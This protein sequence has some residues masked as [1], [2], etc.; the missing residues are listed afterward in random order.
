VVSYH[1]RTVNQPY[2]QII[3]SL[4][5]SNI[6]IPSESEY[7]TKIYFITLEINFLTFDLLSCTKHTLGT[8]NLAPVRAEK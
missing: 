1:F 2:S 3:S 5:D 4:P 7:P 8:S 6:H